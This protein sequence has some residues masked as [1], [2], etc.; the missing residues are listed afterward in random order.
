VKTVALD[1]G[2]THTALVILDHKGSP[3]SAAYIRP[4]QGRLLRLPGH[5]H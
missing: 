2:N 4:A 1:P 3:T 5:G